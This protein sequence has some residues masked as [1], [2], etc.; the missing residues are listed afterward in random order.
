MKKSIINVLK[1][2][3]PILVGIYICYYFW[4]SFDEQQK[5]DFVTVFKQANYAW[6][7]LALIIGFISH[8]SRATR[9]K[10]AL[11][12][13]GYE[14]STFNSYN[15]IMIGY[16]ANILVPRMG[17]ASRAGVLKATDNV[18]FEKGFGSIVAERVIDVVCLAIVSGGALLFNIDKIDD[19]LN[20]A[21]L[22]NKAKPGEE[23]STPWGTYIFLGV[24]MLGVLGFLFLWFRK[25]QFKEK[26]KNFFIG[27]KEGLVSIFKMKDRIPYLA[28]TA[29]IWICYLAMFWV[30]FYALPFTSELSVSAIMA[31][32]VAG[33]IGFIVVQGGIGT[34][35]IMVGAVITFFRNPE[36]LAETGKPLGEDVGF[37]ALVWA[38][39]TILIVG[40]GLVS[41]FLVQRTKNKNKTAQEKQ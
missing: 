26:V 29:L 31:G 20:I 32:F 10:Y 4:T 16:I 35:P 7:G 38:S 39:Q 36:Y 6:V 12:P 40:L 13:L 27:L 33:T 1:I 21:S 17:E 41:L 37:G 8:W 11:K 9:W 14:P 23:A 25:P 28:H 2:V 34:Y 3:I 30:V 22:I 5:E 19:L 24:V 15:A 18:P